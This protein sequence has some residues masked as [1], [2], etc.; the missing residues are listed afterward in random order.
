MAQVASS[1]SFASFSEYYQNGQLS[2]FPQEHR[3]GGSFGLQMLKVDQEADEFT[4][5]PID[6]VSIVGIRTTS[7]RAELD[8]GDGW[9][10]E[11]TVYPGF[12]GPQPA[13]QACG[14]RIRDAS[15]LTAVFAPAKLVGRH[16]D[17]VGIAGDPFRSAYAT[18]SHAP[19][20]MQK[21]EAIWLAL[22]EGGPANNLLVDGL[23]L[24]LLGQM[25]VEQTDRRAFAAVPELGTPQ[26]DRVVDYIEAHFDAPLLSAELAGIAGMSLAQ[27]GRSF[28]AATG[29]TPH[30]YVTL[31]RIE[32]AK[33]F[34]HGR[35]LTL[36]QIAFCCG[37][38]SA[39]HFSSVFR[40]VTGNTPSAY[41]HAIGP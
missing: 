34:L 31:R 18:L 11:T 10:S 27:F 5:P 37:F 24:A 32:H 9:T 25:L 7:A 23:F 1:S 3:T 12:V 8:F 14:F 38:S 41:R 2:H 28:K 40:R 29:A 16:L 17:E 26:L 20:V 30:A 33:R 39:A 36:T 15:H 21:M 13:N 6:Q 22:E 19:H 35:D 4:D